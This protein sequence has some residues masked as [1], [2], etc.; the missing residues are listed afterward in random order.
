ML[1][2]VAAVVCVLSGAAAAPE[3]VT[4]V[5]SSSTS[6]STDSR[7]ATVSTTNFPKNHRPIEEVEVLQPAGGGLAIVMPASTPRTVLF[8]KSSS[9]T[10]PCSADNHVVLQ[11]ETL[12]SFN[13][14]VDEDAGALCDQELDPG[15]YQ[16]RSLA[17]NTIPTSCPAMNHCGTHY[18]IWLR[19]EIPKL[20]EGIVNSQ[21]C[22]H[23]DDDC[24]GH[25]MP[26][27]L[28]NCTDF[29]VYFLQ[30]TPA[31]DMAYC[32]GHMVPCPLGLES[33]TGFTPCQFLVQL[34][35]VKI[36]V[37][38][39][40]A[41]GIEIRC[42]A[43]IDQVKALETV[44]VEVDW[45]DSGI[46]IHQQKY[47]PA[48]QKYAVIPR[49][50]W[51][52]GQ[53]LQCRA[54]VRHISINT[55]TPQVL[56][57]EFFAGIQ[58]LSPNPMQLIEGGNPVELEFTSTL[59]VGC[60]RDNCCIQLQVSVVYP[61]K[62][63]FCPTGEPLD[64]LGVIDCLWNVC[65]DDWNE[66][67]GIP[68]RVRYDNLYHG[69]QQ[70]EIELKTHTLE[71]KDWTDYTM[72]RQQVHVLGVDVSEKCVSS[73]MIHTF[74]GLVY[75]HQLQGTFLLYKNNLH[76]VHV[77]YRPCH[78]RKMCNCAVR[79]QSKYSAFVADYCKK[80]YLQIW[81]ESTNT[82][83][84]LQDITI[85]QQNEG[86]SYKLV[87]PSGTTVVIGPYLSFVNVHV[88]A[89]D[90]GRTSGLCGSFD[91]DGSND[92][93]LPNGQGSACKYQPRASC[94]AFSQHWRVKEF[95]VLD[96]TETGQ[97]D[98]SGKEE[99]EGLY[100][101]CRS[102]YSSKIMPA[103]SNITLV[104]LEHESTNVI[105]KR[106]DDDVI[107]CESS[108]C[109]HK[110]GI[111][112]SE[113]YLKFT[114]SEFFTVKDVLEKQTDVLLK[115]YEKIQSDDHGGE[116]NL[117]DAK[118]FCQNYVANSLAAQQCDYVADVKVSDRIV[119]CAND[120]HTTNDSS[121]A[122][123]ALN[124][125]KYDCKTEI[126]RNLSL[127]EETHDG[128]I[129]PP[130]DLLSSLCINNCSGTGECKNGV[131]MCKG[132]Y[133]G[134]DCSINQNLPPVI[135]GLTMNPCDVQE[136]SCKYVIVS[137]PKFAE[138]NDLR[139][140]IEVFVVKDRDHTAISQGMTFSTAEFLSFQAVIC[141]VPTLPVHSV[142]K[143]FNK[144]STRALV[145]VSVCYGKQCSDPLEL[146]VIDSRCWH[147]D[148]ESPCEPKLH[149][150]CFFYNPYYTE[151]AS[152]EAKAQ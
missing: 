16:F 70:L 47:M 24:C 124:N 34:I 115:P 142:G 57:E 151:P 25:S 44:V 149:G 48:E 106:S 135:T 145:K 63:Y 128:K 112:M 29:I 152:K 137:G 143:H 138:N 5:V 21:G 133:V 41:N 75:E 27:L 6:T 136:T 95:Q 3:N 91:R 9:G 61:E 150:P 81:S 65:K 105:K 122:A 42:Q 43:E 73:S 117:H 2:I 13:Q 76:E 90:M 144:D 23:V 80:G 78:Y 92:L 121:W 99:D 98:R 20:D 36:S 126:Y 28:K 35:D 32:A 146:W 129:V 116:W 96:V 52:L 37:D 148:L 101:A 89:T 10:D 85:I 134:S 26:I 62:T 54:R 111:E 11:D 66:T 4:V 94:E 50:S 147:C 125:L 110:N 55:F 77:D 19:G 88:F 130:S 84:T 8:K 102:P 104:F 107:A 127:W 67:H 39:N 139:C 120:I 46:V 7:P 58:I 49:K 38:L 53:T 79:V 71:H 69:N 72:P 86:R 100:C 74:D 12:R 123:V 31:C 59:P 132:G 15:W 113:E 60:I 22:V 119:E 51:K 14:P 109:F 93:D 82:D 103:A 18:P 56:S 45:L 33:D 140:G 1:L 30:P 68:F 64:R 97:I 141:T 40:K 118:L 87:F 17:G 131:C 108:Q 83:E 114:A